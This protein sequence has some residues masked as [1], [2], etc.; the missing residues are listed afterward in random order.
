MKIESNKSDFNNG[1]PQDKLAKR[2]WIATKRT[3][4]LRVKDFSADQRSANTRPS[5]KPDND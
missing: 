4:S 3:D 1:H 5:T 2:I